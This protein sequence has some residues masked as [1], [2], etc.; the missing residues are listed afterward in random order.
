MLGVEAV[1]DGGHGLGEVAELLHNSRHLL[2]QGGGAVDGWQGDIL[3]FS[4]GVRGDYLEIP[5][6]RVVGSFG[7]F[8]G[9]LG[10]WIA[11]SNH[12]YT[13][14]GSVGS[15]KQLA[16]KPCGG[17]SNPAG[18]ELWVTC[19]GQE[20]RVCLLQSRREKAKGLLKLLLL[21]PGPTGLTVF[22]FHYIIL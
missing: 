17:H 14:Q 4:K 15:C 8:K 12:P 1:V 2:L 16:Q 11:L 18:R 5:Q 22:N 3:P 7:R 21:Q 13:G 10:E 9:L 6:S 19:G 20:L